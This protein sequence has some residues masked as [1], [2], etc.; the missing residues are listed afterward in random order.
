MCTQLNGSIHFLY[1]KNQAKV[2]AVKHQ[3]F[4]TKITFLKYIASHEFFT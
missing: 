1:L 4:I 2:L 3:S